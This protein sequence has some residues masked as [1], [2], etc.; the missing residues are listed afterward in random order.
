MAISKFGQ[1]KGIRVILVI[2]ILAM[3]TAAV[4]YHL[5]VTRSISMPVC[6]LDGQMHQVEFRFTFYRSFLQQT[7]VRGKIICED[8]VYT[9]I[10]DKFESEGQK[11][12]NDIDWWDS[13]LAKYSRNGISIPD[14]VNEEL[15]VDRL[16]I[17]DDFIPAMCIRGGFD[18]EAVELAIGK[19]N[20]GETGSTGKFFYGP[21][22]TAEEAERI[23][24]V[25]YDKTQE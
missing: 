16:E 22:A 24:E 12:D 17:F 4:W 1:N 13:F 23:K 18:L 10:Y 8:T 3:L 15:D 25:F 21:A 19:K 20:P 2:C 5:P 6:A 7:Y 11:I 9:D 14:F